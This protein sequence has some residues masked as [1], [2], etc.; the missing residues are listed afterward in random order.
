MNSLPGR[1]TPAE[2]L[3]R[4]YDLDLQDDPGDLDLW[5]ALAAQAG[6]PILELMAGSGR[7]AVPLAADGYDVT[8]VDVDA[9]MLARAG[10]RAAAAGPEVERRL[11]LVL[12]DV[13]GLELGAGSDAPEA[14][15]LGARSFGL[16]FIALNSILLLPSRDAQRAAWRALA[17]H[18]APDGVAAVDTWLPDARDL[19][20]YDGRLHLEY[21][22][23]DPESGRWVTKTAAAQHDAAS[24]TVAL[25]TIYEEGDPGEPA[26]RWVRRDVV[27]L[28]TAEELRTM[29]EAAGLAVELVAGGYDLEPLGPH[30]DRAVVIARKP[31]SGAA[32]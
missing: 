31:G 20:R 5:T 29:A 1:E 14:G 27:H 11:E 13:L 19:A 9:A 15:A 16:A 8:A 28:V 24:Q 21:H 23:P 30:D 10:R 18:L 12:G 2:A 6:G 3:A 26:S 4:L 7:V 25:T 17:D 32:G 22:R